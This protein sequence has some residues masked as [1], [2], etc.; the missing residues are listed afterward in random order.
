MII[1]ITGTNGA[2][3]GTVVEYLAAK[4]FHHYSASGYIIEE[5]KRRGFTV[6]RPHMRIVGDS[7][8]E[9]RGPAYFSNM[10]IDDAKGKGYEDVI[11][12]SIRN[13]IDAKNIQNR[14]GFI[15]VVDAD[16]H[17]RYE[18]AVAR[19]SEKD[20]VT[21]EQFCE[22]EDR[23][24]ASDKPHEMDI[25]NVMKLADG[26]IYNNGS[27]EELHAQIDTALATLR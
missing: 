23:E 18:R 27:L 9:E 7:L 22:Q 17:L 10:C 8:R 6:D 14:G 19:G 25:V 24:M 26:T 21:F 16:K 1:G 3:K 13:S 5:I 4:G 2:G 11:I 12:E 15:W 20:K